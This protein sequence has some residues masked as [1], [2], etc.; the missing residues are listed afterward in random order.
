MRKATVICGFALILLG[1]GGFYG[2][3]GI[4]P[5]AL[6]PALFGA[7]LAGLAAPPRWEQRRPLRLSAGFIG[8]LGFIGSVNGVVK[9]ISLVAGASV[10]RPTA[11]IVQTVMALICGFYLVLVLRS[12]FRTQLPSGERRAAKGKSV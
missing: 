2:T 5:T 1:L 11:A 3:G 10:P 8:L 12:A 9:V 4:A 7:V 6:I